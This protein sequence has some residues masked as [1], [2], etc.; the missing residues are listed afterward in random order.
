MGY[1]EVVKTVNVCES[2]YNSSALFLMCQE[3]SDVIECKNYRACIHPLSPLAQLLRTPP[4]P[5][6]QYDPQHENHAR[7][8]SAIQLL[9]DAKDA[10]VDIAN[11]SGVTPLMMAVSNVI[12]PTRR[13][14]SRAHSFLILSKM[15]LAEML[16]NPNHPSG[17]AQR[18]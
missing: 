16:T 11:S 17:C 12:R 5:Y 8:E 6:H 13:I 1:P 15:L 2:A 18:G 7:C 10:V 4:L 14:H 3:V 9:L